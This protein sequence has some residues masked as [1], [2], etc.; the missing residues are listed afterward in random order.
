MLEEALLI[1]ED[2]LLA[3]DLL[4][5]ESIKT[6]SLC[7]SNNR[8]LDKLCFRAVEDFFLFFSFLALIVPFTID[9]CLT[10]TSDSFTV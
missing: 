9:R 8:E 3:H 4:R 2:S 10:T 6:K 1:A 7:Y 5:K